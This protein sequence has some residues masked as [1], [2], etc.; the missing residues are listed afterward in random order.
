MTRFPHRVHLSLGERVLGIMGFAAVLL[1]AAG[2]KAQ[3]A[4]DCGTPGL[5]IPDLQCFLGAPCELEI[6]LDSGAQD[7]ASVDG[8]LV[9]SAGLEC[10]TA[11]AAGSAA[12]NGS[13]FAN[14]DCQFVVADI[15]LDPDITAFDDGPIA[16]LRV[17]CHSVGSFPLNVENLTM[18]SPDGFAV[19]GAC[20]SPGNIR[21]DDPA[22]AVSVTVDPSSLTERCFAP[23]ADSIEFPVTVDS[24][25]NQMLVVSVGAEEPDD[26]CDL[27][28]A[29][30]T[31]G[32]QAMVAAVTSVSDST[33][34]RTCNG[35]FYLTNPPAG[36]ANVKVQFP[37]TTGSRMNAPHAAAFIVLNADPSG[38]TAVAAFGSENNANSWSHTIQVPSPGALVIALD[39]VGNDGTFVFDGPDQAELWQMACGTS[40]SGGSTVRVDAPG[41]VG[42]SFHHSGSNRYAESVV[43]FSPLASPPTTLP[44]ECTG[45]SDCNDGNPCTHD[46]CVAGQCFY[47]ANAAS[48]SDGVGCTVGDRCMGGTC[49]PGP[50]SHGLCDDG[51]TCTNDVCSV[52]SGCVHTNACGDAVMLD[53]TTVVSI[54][55]SAPSDSISMPV[56]VTAH[57]NSILVVTVGGEESDQDCDLNRATAHFNGAPMT[58]AVAAVSD[59]IVWR[60]C[61]GIFYLV[62]PNPGTG[63]VTVNFPTTV[64]DGINNRQLAAYVLYNADES[65]P[66]TT[67]AFGSEDNFNAWTNVLMAEPTGALT[68]DIVTVGND[69]AIAFS[70]PGQS[71]VWEA[72]C[73]SSGSAGSKAMVAEAGLQVLTF[74]HP[75]V[76]RYAQSVAVFRPAEAPPPTTT[77]TTLPSA[78]EVGIDLASVAS[79]CSGAVGD[80]IAVPVSVGSGANRVLVV[81]AGGE[82]SDLDCDL[83]KASVTYGGAQLEFA[84]G[85]ASDLSAWRACSGIFYLVNPPVGTANVVVDFATA[86]NDPINNRQVAALVLNGA[87]S[88]GPDST[89]VFGA[90]PIDSA[91]ARSLSVTRPGSV[92]I[93]IPT[94]GNVGDH[95][96]LS[97]Q[98]VQAIMSCGSSSSVIATT[99]FLTG[100]A[101]ESAWGHSSPNRVAY[102]SVIWGPAP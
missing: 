87:D 81:A 75:N 72:T 92:A 80:S 58:R 31:Y 42:L 34:W 51:D 27:A 10:S 78:G 68:V 61:N 40:S 2:A 66:S 24:G 88:S 16:S 33:R 60:A 98:T 97:G 85:T 3:P 18:G 95:A 19:D 12:E 73:D 37:T 76:N 1:F 48:C 35:T 67:A 6:S 32:G 96:A 15:S 43:V 11:C 70:G 53:E 94:Y 77:T 71:E 57:D 14:A 21:C 7:V 50:A 54:C 9:G 36:T 89:D 45:D 17:L 69:A 74:S 84:V 83:S 30:V 8:D 38:P 47:M 64:G 25:S 39:T 44:S 55:Q 5:V 4:A 41:A 20:S 82:E 46:S 23:R 93:E 86:T 56:Q 29:S 28:A 62:D 65:G 26:D 63:M 13:C 100:G 79:D 102:S 91:F 90:E 49:V 99:N 52:D 22:G 101:S 59:A